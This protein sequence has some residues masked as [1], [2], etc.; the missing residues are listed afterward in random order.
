MKLFLKRAYLILLVSP[1]VLGMG[2]VFVVEKVCYFVGNAAHT[3]AEV[4]ED[5]QRTEMFNSWIDWARAK[6]RLNNLK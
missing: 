1:L 6:A 3:A 5:I 4:A 2:V